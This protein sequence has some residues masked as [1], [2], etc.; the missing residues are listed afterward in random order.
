MYAK[1]MDDFNQI[2]NE[3]MIIFI[4]IKYYENPFWET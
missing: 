3:K 2:I 4:N 1:D